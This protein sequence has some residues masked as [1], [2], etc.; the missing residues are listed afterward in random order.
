MSG[1]LFT[2]LRNTPVSSSG[3]PYPGALRYFYAAGT[4]TKVSVYSDSALT[5]QATNPQIADS[6]GKFA[7]VYLNPTLGTYKTVLT[8]S[9]GAQLE[10]DDNIPAAAAIT[11]QSVGEALYPITQAETDAD[12]TPTDYTYPELD[13]RRYG[14]DAGDTTSDQS[15][16]LQEAYDVA[17]ELGGGVIELPESD[18][19]A[20]ISIEHPGIV[21]RGQ[22]GISSATIW[23]NVGATA[24]VTFDNADRGIVGAG[25]K[26]LKLANR[27]SGTYT[28]TDGLKISS[29]ATGLNQMDYLEFDDIYVLNFRDNLSITG[30]CI[31]ADFNKV[32]CEGAIRDGLS[33]TGSDNFSQNNF[34]LCRFGNGGRH[35]FYANLTFAGLLATANRFDTCTFEQNEENGVRI[36]GT[37]GFAGLSFQSCYMEENSGSITASDT[38]PRKVN[39]HV[40]CV[41]AIGLDIDGATFYGNSAP[42][43]DIDQNIYV[44]TTSMTSVSG[45]VDNCRFNDAVVADVHWQKGVYLGNNVYSAVPS[46][47]RSLGSVSFSDQNALATW[48]PGLAFGAATTGLTYT[49]QVGRYT[50]H[51]RLVT[52]VAYIT[53]NDNGSASGAATITGLPYTA[54]NVTNLRVACAMGGDAFGGSLAAPIWAEVVPNT[55]TAALFKL[56][57]GSK[58][59][60]TESDLANGTNVAVTLQYFV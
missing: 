47:D 48:T 33:L 45:T 23:R 51:G 59:A 8:N 34:R 44:D 27:D 53:I 25:L 42:D 3:R 26:N 13:V 32:R 40:D 30:R 24:P 18:F 10:S 7:T 29:E 14:F 58:T 60:I 56:V 55:T 20:T 17:V 35:G 54:A 19:R 2:P 28:T 6:A 43:A 22:G 46:I 57:T 16:P 52:A 36:T 31:W 11:G 38:D 5:T 49:T 4:T 1:V 50:V 39:I 9:G 15:A 41:Y 12:I 21:F 37:Y